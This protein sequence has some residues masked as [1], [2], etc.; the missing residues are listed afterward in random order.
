MPL[1]PVDTDALWKTTGAG[2]ASG[3]QYQENVIVDLGGLTLSRGVTHAFER[4]S[5]AIAGLLEGVPLQP[6][7]LAGDIGYSVG[8]LRYPLEEREITAYI[9]IHPK[10]ETSRVASADCTYYGYHL[11]CPQGKTLLRGAYHKRQRS[12]HH[13]A[14]QKDRQARP[15]K[16]TCFPPGQKRRFFGV[17]Y[18]TRSMRGHESG[19]EPLLPDGRTIGARPS[20][21][22]PSPLR[23]GWVGRSPD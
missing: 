5:K 22:E 1:N 18:I 10:Q 20:R 11:V 9:P 13:A 8:R 19:T 6:V 4:E 7:S 15:V 21:K 3:L 23:A 2:K 17:P 12:Y 16:D 14:R